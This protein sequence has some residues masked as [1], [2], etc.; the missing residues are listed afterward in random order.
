MP[1][2]MTSTRRSSRGVANTKKKYNEIDS[3]DEEQNE[4]FFEAKDFENYITFNR[5]LPEWMQD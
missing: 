2:K 4:E 1:F 3:D 5:F